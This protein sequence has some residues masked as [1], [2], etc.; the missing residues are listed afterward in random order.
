VNVNASAFLLVA[1]GG[2][3]G[4]ALRFTVAVFGESIGVRSFWATL[5]VNVLGCFALGVLLVRVPGVDSRWRLAL[6]TGVLG[7]FTTF[8]TF[9]ADAYAIRAQSQPLALAY[10]AASVLLGF[11]AFSLGTYWAER[12]V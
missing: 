12:S 2:A 1:L 4:A 9:A 7:G 5:L 10:A 8:S 3:V 11:A 6:G